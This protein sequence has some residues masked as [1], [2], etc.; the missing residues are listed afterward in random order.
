MKMSQLDDF[1]EGFADGLGLTDQAEIR[2]CYVQW[3]RGVQLTT[4]ELLDYQSGGY[5]TGLETGA[6]IA[7]EM[8]ILRQAQD[9][10]QKNQD[11]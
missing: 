11:Q 4:D 1:L 7:R 10:L 9:K 8:E 5:Q 6:E 3:R 2:I